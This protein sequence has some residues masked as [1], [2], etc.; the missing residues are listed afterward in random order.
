[1]VGTLQLSRALPD[2]DLSDQL[3]APAV[4]TALMLLEDS[5]RSTT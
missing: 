2:R 1:M 4:E 5:A 3:L